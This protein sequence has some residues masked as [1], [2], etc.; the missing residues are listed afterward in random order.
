MLETIEPVLNENR[1]VSCSEIKQLP[2]G[3]FRDIQSSVPYVVR[4]GSGCPETYAGQSKAPLLFVRHPGDVRQPAF[5]GG[6][7]ST[8]LYTLYVG[9]NPE[10]PLPRANND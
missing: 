3:A 8:V 10:V 6:R 7:G 5:A 9:W 4:L 1:A 2:T